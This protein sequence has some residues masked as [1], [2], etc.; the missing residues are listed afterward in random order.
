MGRIDGTV[1]DDRIIGTVDADEIYGGAG[2]DRINGGQGDDVI[3]G[4]DDNDYVYGDEGNDTLHGGLGND[5]LVGHSGNDTIFG[6]DGN[7]GIF[8]GGGNDVV[9]GGTGNDTIY[10]DGGNDVIDGGAGDDR[11]FGGTGNDTLLYTAGDGIDELNGNTGIDTVRIVM[12]SADLDASRGDFSDFA[13]W[14]EN[15]LSSAGGE[16]AYAGRNA[17]ETF[18]LS[19]LGLTVSGVERVEFVVDGDSVTL[20]DVMNRAPVAAA[21]QSLAVTEDSSVSGNVGAS[22]PDGDTLNSAVAQGPANGAVVMDAATGDFTYTPDADFSGSD[23]FSVMIEDGR[24]GAVEQRIN[25]AIDAEADTPALV[26]AVGEVVGENIDGSGAII[27]T[28]GS[29]VITGGSGSDLIVGDAGP[30]A[31]ITYNLDIT[32]LSN[33]ADGSEALTV[34]IDGV[35]D[36]GSLSAGEDLGNGSC[37]LSQGQ[38]EGLTLTLASAQDVTLQVTATSTEANGAFQSVAQDLFVEAPTQ[39][40]N[41]V[42]EGGAGNDIIIGGSGTDT[43]SYAG[44]DAGVEVDLDKG[45]SSGGAGKDTLI[46][47]ENIVGSA[48][49]DELT[50]DQND[51]VIN[52]GAGDDTLTG[53]RGVD[54][55]TGGAGSD[56]FSFARKDVASG[57]THYGVDRITDFGAGDRLDF[58]ELLKGMKYGD[59]SDVIQLTTTDEGTMISVDIKGYSGFADVVFLEGVFDLDL[60]FLDGGGQLLV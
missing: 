39:G 6:D 37:E 35:P 24:S 54:I 38:L 48:Y 20:Q 28:P 41:D 51:N 27:G 30:S 4:G 17:T 5:A 55:L 29:D 36:G 31:A 42:I 43:A 33:D 25:I 26:A 15:Q 56:T 8:A 45:K 58:E 11:L 50:G 16:G 46:G 10:G 3:D 18:S 40:G 7:D 52:A 34:K 9:S 19:G 53:G 12:T 49:D 44:A 14:L 47:I 57:D 22:D 1:G 21:E 32:V 59:L 23:S 2:R 13:A 60:D